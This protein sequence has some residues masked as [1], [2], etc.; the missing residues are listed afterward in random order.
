MNQ[1]LQEQNASFKSSWH[2]EA[3]KP[4]DWGFAK[5][6]TVLNQSDSAVVHRISGTFPNGPG[7]ECVCVCARAHMWVT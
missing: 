2:S 7:G 6:D 1:I 3:R 5:V 4:W